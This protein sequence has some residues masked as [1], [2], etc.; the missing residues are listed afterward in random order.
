MAASDKEDC[1]REIEDN[2]SDL[3]L[4]KLSSKVKEKLSVTKVA[5]ILRTGK[6]IDVLICGKTGCG[7]STLVNGMMGVEVMKKEAANEGD[8][9]GYCTSKVK[10]YK[11]TKDR[12]DITVWDTPGLMDGTGKEKSYLKDIQDTCPSIHLKLFCIDC[13]QTRFVRGP[14]NA[15]FVV[16][17]KFTD[18]FGTEF[19]SNTI[20]V[21]TMANNVSAY[22]PKWRTMPPAEMKRKYIQHMDEFTK[23]IRSLLIED[24]ALPEDLVS[25]IKIVPAGYYSERNLPDRDYWLSNFFF[26]CLDALHSPEAKGAL[27]NLNLARFKSKN[28]VEESNF[29]EDAEN[30]PIVTDVENAYVIINETIDNCTPPV[31]SANVEGGIGA[32]GAAGIGSGVGGVVGT[33]LGFIGLLG[34]PLA[35]ITVPAGAAVGASIGAGLGYFT[36]KMMGTG[37]SVASSSTSSSS[38]VS[39]SNTTKDS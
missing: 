20:I 7:K 38:A 34:G 21:L 12:I 14:N 36:K 23:L 32:G 30:Q 27:L 35:F 29:S 13:S 26:E 22:K 8:E 39:K 17:K 5:A 16:M 11:E 4:S 37:E 24:L 25:K 1:F 31:G 6:S 28:E 33:G 2:E 3:D 19:W 18:A 15:D 9:L 10:P